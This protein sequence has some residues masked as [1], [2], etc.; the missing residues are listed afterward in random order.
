MSWNTQ[1]GE[2]TVDE[3]GRREAQE[4]AQDLDALSAGSSDSV[5]R[6]VARP[7][8]LRRVAMLLAQGISPEV[9][10]I[11][12]GG[13]G[14]EVLGAGV[15]LV[16]G[17]PFAVAGDAAAPSIGEVHEG[18]DVVVVAADSSDTEAVAAWC[19]QRGAVVRGVLVVFGEGEALF[20]LGTSGRVEAGWSA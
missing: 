17:L 4:L 18:E 3:A 9:T 6:W 15:A 1:T 20:R 10:R 5:A 11:V 12:T 7:A 8:V 14:A 13:A 16:S 2:L 19:R